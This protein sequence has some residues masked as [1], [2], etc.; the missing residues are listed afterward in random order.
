[1]K[2]IRREGSTMKLR[3][4]RLSVAL[5]AVLLPVLP[6]GAVAA[7]PANA[8]PEG[9]VLSVDGASATIVRDAFGV[10][11]IY[12]PSNR[13]LFV[14]YGYA[15]AQDRLWQL[16]LNRRAARGRLAE[17]FGPSVVAADTAARTVGYT[18]MEL[19]VQFARVG[20]EEQG[21]FRAYAEGI[22]RYLTEVVAA[23][24]RHAL[25]FEFHALGITPEAWTLR[26]SVA[27][28]AFMTRRFGEIG[29]RHLTNQSLLDHLVKRFG[30]AA[31]YA[32]FND[33]RWR[34]DP[35]A[36]VTVPPAGGQ[37]EQRE[38]STEVAAQLEGA[39]ADLPAGEDE[40]TKTWE[41]LGV[42]TKL[43]SYAWVVSPSRS[44]NRAA[45]LYGGPQMGFS[46]PE[47][48]H[49]VQLTGGN[50]FNV[51]GMAFAGVPAVLIGRNA[52]VAWTSTT[53]TGGNVDTYLETLCGADRYVFR[54]QCTAMESRVESI[55]VRGAA[56]IA[57]PVRRTVHGPVVGGSGAF[58]VSQKRAHW[59]REIESI[60]SFIAFDRARDLAGFEAGVKAIVT[61]H[62]FLYA[63]QQGNIAYWQAG[64]VPL[65]PAGFDPRLPFPGDGRAE[66]PGGILPMPKSVNPAQG[67]LANWN[68]KPSV[69]YDNADSQI[70]GK[71]FRLLDLQ[72]RLARGAIS[73]GDMRDIPKD[74]ARFGGLG[75]ESRYL[76]PYLLEGIEAVAPS[77]PLA[78]RAVDLLEDWNGNAFQDAVASTTLE[79]AEV[80][81]ASWLGHMIRRTFLDA[82]G[83]KVNE[84]SS[85][86]LL[87]VLD[88]ALGPGSG[89]PPS[90]DYF[91]GGD[92]RAAISRA[93]DAALTELQASRGGDPSAW[94]PLRGTTTFRHPILGPVGSIPESNRATYAQIVVLSR[95]EIS[96][97]NIFTLGQSG[98]ASLSP[99][100]GFVLDPHFRD[101]LDLYRNFQY[102]PM[103]LTPAD[104][105]D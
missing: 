24:P 39:A 11:H 49:E 72:D 1:M 87:H 83:P 50:G 80:I 64:Q 44:A 65:R 84:A 75:R 13:A 45:M 58:A 38:E 56:P 94:R 12:A 91:N 46:A 18:D 6:L 29:G 73:L 89:V 23:D 21:I 105:D 95:P 22:N 96:S 36:P 33:V 93:F 27:F 102:K 98:F 78:E 5:L 35:N 47:V 40:A 62:N 66:W 4:M 20:S 70:F 81:F 100:G 42:A 48:L 32:A 55:K 104:T 69:D 54:G 28:G 15:V 8:P 19:D 16:E 60:S 17:L 74:I 14:A 85:N 53:A 57:L 9:T 88:A 99:T 97:E 76:L 10:P 2:R 7:I 68:N 59:Q 61:S 30:A 86:M 101:Q 51:T 41:R 63:D 71:Q 52:R 43:G 82:L 103:R 26:D 67:Y 3:A 31:G 90:R 25:P 34:N 77:H 37:R 79:P 92:P